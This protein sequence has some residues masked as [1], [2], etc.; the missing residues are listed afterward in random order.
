MDKESNA[1]QEFSSELSQKLNSKLYDRLM[2]M[3]KDIAAMILGEKTS[4]L[5]KE[6]KKFFNEKLKEQGVK[7]VNDLD[8]KSKKSFFASL[9]KEWEKKKKEF[10]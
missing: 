8:E 5:Q 6:Y 1:F 4:P 7:S 2:E 3:K 9:S 10:E